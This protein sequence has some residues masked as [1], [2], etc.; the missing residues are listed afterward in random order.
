MTLFYMDMD[1]ESG[2][3]YWVRAG[4]D[5]ALIYDPEKKMFLELKG[6]GLP[7]G[8][9]HTYLYREYKLPSLQVGS[10]IAMGTDGIWEARNK[11]K[12]FFGKKHFR[13][14]VQ[15]MADLSAHDIVCAVFDALES[16]CRGV[17][18]DDD[19]TLVIVKVT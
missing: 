7:L 1:L 6:G 5:P 2:E 16:Y 17:P 12:M 10:I 4:H 15:E 8:V 18:I 13:H 11:K 19:M 9:D 14:I 3:S